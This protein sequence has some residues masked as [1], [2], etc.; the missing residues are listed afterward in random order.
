MDWPNCMLPVH[1]WRQ[2]YKNFLSN[3]TFGNFFFLSLN[4]VA[5]LVRMTSKTF[6]KT[7][8]TY[9]TYTVFTFS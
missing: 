7:V 3:I 4:V 8:M 5:I 9:C 6:Y 1:H 2:S